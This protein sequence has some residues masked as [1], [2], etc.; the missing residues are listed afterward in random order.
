[1]VR[2]TLVEA[3]EVDV[4]EQLQLEVA[5]GLEDHPLVGRARKVSHDGLDGGRV[6]LLRVGAE[7]GGLADGEGDVGAR[8]GQ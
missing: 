6:G 3:G 2:F 8:V 7:A 4:A 1:L 5:S